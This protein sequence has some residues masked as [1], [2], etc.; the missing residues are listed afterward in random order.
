VIVRGIVQGVGFRFSVMQMAES[1]SV[2]G[3]VRNRLDGSVEA[4]FEGAPDA[5]ESMVR[6][7]QHGS[8]GS[9]VEHVE[10]QEEEPE[11]LHGFRAW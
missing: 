6:W 1:R 7:C 9:R 3:W 8:R 5:V 4:V 11:G 2:A 10:I